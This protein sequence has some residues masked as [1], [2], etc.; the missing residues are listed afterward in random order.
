[1]TIR[2]GDSGR[3][4]R[5]GLACWIRYANRQGGF[6]FPDEKPRFELYDGLTT[7]FAETAGCLV[8]FEGFRP[9]AYSPH[10][11]VQIL[12]S[13]ADKYEYRRLYRMVGARAR[14][15]SADPSVVRSL[16][17]RSMKRSFAFKTYRWHESARQPKQLQMIRERASRDT[18]W[19]SRPL[20]RPSAP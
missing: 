2:E 12:G 20:R 9:L 14:T 5:R 11:A 8:F 10:R 13:P 4:R 7:S 18:P 6:S 17:N 19:P 15:G 16:K 1:M 3:T